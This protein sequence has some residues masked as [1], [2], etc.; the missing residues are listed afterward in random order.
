V[1]EFCVTF[2]ILENFDCFH[3]QA[4]INRNKNFQGN[5]LARRS[6]GKMAYRGVARDRLSGGL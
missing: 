5:G 6:V 1:S 4:N 2:E 3:I